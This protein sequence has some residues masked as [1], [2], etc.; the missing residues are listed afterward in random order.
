RRVEERF[1][2]RIPA[3]VMCV[4]RADLTIS[5]EA[6]LRIVTHLDRLPKILT[7]RVLG[8]PPTPLCPGHSTNSAS[9]TDASDRF[10]PIPY[11]LTNQ[12]VVILRRKMRTKLEA[13][14]WRRP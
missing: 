10:A 1:L 14:S 13:F 6:G 3:G 9:I 12:F 8:D 5:G 11:R 7:F 2:Q 4:Y